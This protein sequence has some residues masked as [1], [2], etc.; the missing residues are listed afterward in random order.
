[1]DQIADLLTRMRNAIFKNKERVDVGFSKL[2]CE[3]LRVLKEEGYI[4]NFKPIHGENKGGVIRIF[5]KYMPDKK[6][7]IS[8]IK[9]MSRP[10][11]RMYRPFDDMPKVKGAFGISV[12]STSHGVMTDSSAR[13]EKVGGEII[14]QVW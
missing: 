10:G 1:M 13:K 12:V 9:R 14:C 2:K 11:R 8:G 3:I 4:I 6:P 7:V 5:L